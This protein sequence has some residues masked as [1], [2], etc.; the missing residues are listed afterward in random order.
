VGCALA[1]AAVSASGVAHACEGRGVAVASA[2]LPRDSLP[3]AEA[4]GSGGGAASGGHSGGG[5]VSR[6][7]RRLWNR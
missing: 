1:P 3:L 6:R 7:R 5:F 4:G 2:I